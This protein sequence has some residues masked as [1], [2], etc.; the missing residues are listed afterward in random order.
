MKMTNFESRYLFT[1]LILFSHICAVRSSFIYC[2]GDDADDSGHCETY[3]A[4]G[5]LMGTITGLAVSKSGVQSTLKDALLVGATG[6]ARS[7]AVNWYGGGGYTYDE[8]TE[9]DDILAVDFT[10]YKVSAS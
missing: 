1:A 2:T 8:I 6:R 10:N 3:Y 9:I 4:C 5:G 7:A